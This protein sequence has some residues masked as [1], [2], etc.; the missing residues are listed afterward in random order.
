[1]PPD[2]A[3]VFFLLLQLRFFDTNDRF[4]NFV[5]IRKI[6][7]VLFLLLTSLS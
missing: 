7:E 2:H 4:F 3:F 6:P 1:M 5:K